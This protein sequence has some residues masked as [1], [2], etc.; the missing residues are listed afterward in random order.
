M[1]VV[2]RAISTMM[3]NVCSFRTCSQNHHMDSQLQGRTRQRN[4]LSRA[5]IWKFNCCRVESRRTKEHFYKLNFHFVSSSCLFSLRRL[6]G[7]GSTEE[8]MDMVLG[9]GGQQHH[10]E[11]DAC[12]NKHIIGNGYLRDAKTNT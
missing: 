12:K 11:A 7:P 9:R 5:F 3:A 8:A 4:K 2:K 1:K 10:L 6:T